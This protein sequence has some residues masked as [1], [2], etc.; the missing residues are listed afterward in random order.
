MGALAKLGNRCAHQ[1]IIP[2]GGVERNK[3]AQTGWGA[4]DGSRI[5]RECPITLGR[6]KG[7]G[8]R[9]KALTTDYVLI[10]RNTP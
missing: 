6:I 8:R 9:G 4:V 3:F 7:Q 10:Y 2:T 1:C 5:R